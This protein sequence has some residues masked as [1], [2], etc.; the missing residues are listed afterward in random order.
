MATVARA[1]AGAALAPVYWPSW[2]RGGK[3]LY[4]I[5]SSAKATLAAAWRAALVCREL[6]QHSLRRARRRGICYSLAL[7]S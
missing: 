4:Q 6:K 3:G 5:A 7:S 2:A 1:T